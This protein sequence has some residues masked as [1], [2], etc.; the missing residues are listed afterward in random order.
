MLEG[1]IILSSERV[2]DISHVPKDFIT[3]S[4]IVPG[5]LQ[6]IPGVPIIEYEKEIIMREP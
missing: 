5:K 4:S 2:L 6:I 1:M 3:V